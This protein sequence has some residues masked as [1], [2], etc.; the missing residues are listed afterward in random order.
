MTPTQTK[1]S[2][3]PLLFLWPRD[4]VMH[5]YAEAAELPVDTLYLGESVCSRRQQLRTRDWIDLARDLAGTGKEIL[6]SSQTLMESDSDM[7]RLNQLADNGDI[8]LEANDLGAVDLMRERGLPFVAGP[9]L[10][11]Y[12]GDTLA[13]MK[14]L[15]AFRWIPPVE[16]SRAMLEAVLAAGVQIETELFA[17]GRLPLAFSARCFTARHYNLDKD[18]CEFRC[19]DHPDGMLLET[20][21][22]ESFLAING[23][24][25]LSA[26]CHS[27]LDDIVKGQVP[28]VDR[29]R[30]SPQSEGTGDVVRAFRAALD[31]ETPVT[32]AAPGP[33]V[34]GYW[35]GQPGIAGQKE[36][37]HAH[38]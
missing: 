21:E 9:H 35:H 34:N 8:R 19:I 23:I 12:N 26:G 2:L 17:W 13:L 5:F 36:A 4:T 11:I 30:I 15:G 28:R 29:L 25:T 16:M 3:G 38:S 31:G 37:L 27:V 33:L 20:R 22:S 7:K 6:L 1:L 18:S 14:R 10:N 24:Q 32:P